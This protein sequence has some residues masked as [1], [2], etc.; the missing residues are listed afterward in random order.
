[1]WERL[2]IRERE[3]WLALLF[4]GV[5]RA[6]LCFGLLATSC[7]LAAEVVLVFVLGIFWLVTLRRMVALR[8]S[9]CDPAP[10]GPLSPDERIKARSKLL[11]AGPPRLVLR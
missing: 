4:L 9:R 10:V 3:R 5:M 6:I 2:R 8:Q 11:G 1:M 7:P